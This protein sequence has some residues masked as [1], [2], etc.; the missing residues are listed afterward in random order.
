M[1][2]YEVVNSTSQWIS[3]NLK[4]ENSWL[5][6]PNFIF[7]VLAVLGLK[8][9]T[10]RNRGKDVLPGQKKH[11]ID[12]LLK[13]GKLAGTAA[14]VVGLG[15]LL[16]LEETEVEEEEV[17]EL[18]KHGLGGMGFNAS[19]LGMGGVYISRGTDLEGIAVLETAF[20]M[21]INYFDTASS[22]GRGESELTYGIWLQGLVSD[23]R[24]D[25]IFLA[26]KALKRD[27]ESAVVEIETSFERLGVETIDLLQVHAINN[28][29][30]WR[31]VTG[32]GGSMK[33]ITE[34]KESGR[35]KHVGISGHGNPEMILR[36]IEEY[37]FESVLV[38][39]G[40]T[41]RYYVPFVEEVLPVCVAKGISVV[42]MKVFAEGKLT[43][44]DVSL[45]KCL[46]YTLSLPISTAIV[47]MR[48]VDEVVQNIAWTKSFVG[49]T[50]EQADS[51]ENEVK[52]KIDTEDLWWKS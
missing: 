9:S 43:A 1:L 15:G 24:R 52:G 14:T 38:P 17:E 42:A 51:L 21:G 30:T 34:A 32:A 16:L 26:T 27:Y 4:T 37:P 48:S 10:R 46:H 39:L 36:A 28:E 22:Y 19:V 5:L 47:G 13:A 7:T 29:E 49:L 18:P 20:Q 8:L 45:E 33:A 31:T 3:L 50:P 35:V 12:R 11:P 6:I 40:I 25:D 2:L 44:T 23:G 41:D